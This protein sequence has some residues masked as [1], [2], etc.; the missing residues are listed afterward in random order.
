MLILES[1]CY[2]K[3][4]EPLYHSFMYSL[5]SLLSGLNLFRD[6]HSLLVT[7][8]SYKRPALAVLC[9]LTSSWLVCRPALGARHTRAYLITTVG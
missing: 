1:Q 9:I 4:T 6:M 5:V 7:S 8:T 2:R 3:D